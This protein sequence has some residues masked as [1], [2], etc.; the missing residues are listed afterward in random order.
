MALASL[1]GQAR[2]VPRARRRRPE[3]DRARR[4]GR[5]RRG[6]LRPLGRAARDARS[7]PRSRTT[8]RGRSRACVARAGRLPDRPRRRVRGSAALARARPSSR[9]RRRTARSG[10][11]TPASAG[12]TRTTGA[13][14]TT[15][16][17]SPRSR[18]GRASTRSS[19]T[20]SASRPTATSTAIVYP[21]QDATPPGWVIAEF[22]HYAAKRLRPLGVRVSADVF[23]LAA[24]R[25]LG[26]GQIPRRIAQVRRRRLPDGLPVA[27][28]LGRVRARGSE[29]RARRDRRVLARPLPPRAE[30][31]QGA[32]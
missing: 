11:T 30:A 27:L 5:E 29:R 18:R 21:G 25:D 24:T 32:S 20:T 3:H 16:S 22:V 14:G 12:R 13:S 26:I 4:Q 1:D 9:S 6:R 15:T 10:A 7:A 17:R 31:G 8:G 28:R 2:G 19:S 23:G